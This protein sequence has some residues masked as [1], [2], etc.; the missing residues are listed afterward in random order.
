MTQATLEPSVIAISP[1]M[2]QRVV[3]SERLICKLNAG[4]GSLFGSFEL[5]MMIAPKK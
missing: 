3:S 4:F 1:E 5:K 2:S